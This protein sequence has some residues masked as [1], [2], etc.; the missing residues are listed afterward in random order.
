MKTMKKMLSFFLKMKCT[1]QKFFWMGGKLN[2]FGYVCVDICFGEKP[3]NEKLI[4]EDSDKDVVVLSHMKQS[5]KPVIGTERLLSQPATSAPLN[6]PP[7]IILEEDNDESSDEDGVVN[8]PMIPALA[9]KQDNVNQNKRESISKKSP[10]FVEKK[11]RFEFKPMGFTIQADE[12][13]EEILVEYVRDNSQASN[14]NVRKGWQ[15]LEINGKRDMLEMLEI[16]ESG[17]GPFDIVFKTNGD[18]PPTS[19][20]PNIGLSSSVQT[21]SNKGH[22]PQEYSIGSVK[23]SHNRLQSLRPFNSA[24]FETIHDE[25]VKAEVSRL[26]KTLE[27]LTAANE[28]LREEV[29]NL[30]NRGEVKEEDKD[31][32]IQNLETENEQLKSIIRRQAR[33]LET[34]G[35][36][37]NTL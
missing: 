27:Q 14:Y 15:L 36:N 1:A 25:A 35:L 29:T 3:K 6:N 5:S 24:I 37:L 16:L 30:K 26:Q 2:V 28:K 12:L 19:Q 10:R 31:T 4:Q 22:A 13:K 32:K 33:V 17:N 7:S 9:D 34:Y 21:P 18:N 8:I 23:S 11:F 20:N